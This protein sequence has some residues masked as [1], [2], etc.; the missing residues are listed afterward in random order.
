MKELMRG[1]HPLIADERKTSID[2]KH[3]QRRG[4]RDEHDIF[5]D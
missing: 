2:K 5:G 3:E 1:R 4:S